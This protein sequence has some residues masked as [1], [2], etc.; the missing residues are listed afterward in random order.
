MKTNLSGG[1]LTTSKRTLPRSM[2]IAGE[3]VNSAVYFAASA[4]LLVA[5]PI[6]PGAQSQAQIV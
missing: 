1:A 4:A 2:P 6:L 5:A 3:A